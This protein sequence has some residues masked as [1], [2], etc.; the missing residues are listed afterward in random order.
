MAVKPV[1]LIL[2]NQNAMSIY[3]DNNATTRPLVEVIEAVQTC[4]REGYGNP[5][6]LHQA[7]RN[8]REEV[9]LARANVAKLIGAENP[10][11]IVFTSGGTESIS[12]VF[13]IARAVAE[14]N[15]TVP[16]IGHST[17]EHA[18]VLDAARVC[19][20]H[21]GTVK[22]V[23]V[24]VNGA[25][26]LDALDAVLSGMA[27]GTFVFLMLAN[28]ETGVVFDIPKAAE[29]CR[30]HGAFLHVD[31]VQAVGKIPVNVDS[32]GCDY[33][34]LSAHK[35]HGIKGSGALYIRRGCPRAPLVPGHQE[36]GL[37]GGTENVPGILAMGVAAKAA[38]DADKGAEICSLMFPLRQRLED[39]ILASVPG[40]AVNGAGA[41]RIS[42]TSNIFFPGKDAA[43]LVERLSTH[44]VYVSAGAACSTGGEPSHVLRAMG[45]SELRANASLRFS[46]SR[47]TT[48]EEIDAA[49]AIVADVVSTSLDV[50]DHG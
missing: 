47:F 6:S 15:T 46:L 9:E 34:S 28:N 19:A 20:A 18:A 27:R 5:S 11:D 29:L 14:S 22:T 38:V 21:G 31:A 33:L 44:G 3:L 7:G 40:S 42:S 41:C 45:L 26:D 23:G 50:F 13:A 16:G 25:L 1:A 10:A 39:A 2:L 4:L 35:F 17:V 37:R 8:A 49:V 12:H 36:G 43:A 48:V 30:K 24:D 32:L